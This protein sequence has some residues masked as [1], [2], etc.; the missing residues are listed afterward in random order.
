MALKTDPIAPSDLQDMEHLPADPHLL[1]AAIVDSSDDAIV[2]KNLDGIILSWNRAAERLFGYSADEVI[3]KSIRTVIP[4]ERQHEEDMIIGKLR[5]GERIDHYETVRMRKN[6][7]RFPISVTISPIRDSSGTVVAASKIARDISDRKRLDESRFRLAAIV[8]SADDAIISKDLDGIVLTWNRG[9]EKIFGYTAEE[10]IGQSI[11]CLFPDEL[12]HEEDEL[13]RKMR[14]GE[15]IDH[16]ETVRKKKNGQSVDISV[17][18]SPIRDETGNVTAVSKIARDVSDKKRVE[19][20][21]LQSEKLAAMGRMAAAV[22][23]EINNPLE[24]L[25]NLIYLAR[26]NSAPGGKA[27][28][29]LTTAEEEMERLAHMARQTLGYYKDTVSP[30]EV[31]LH[32]LIENVL[33]VYNTR[34]MSTGI[35]LDTRFNDLKKIRVSKGEM[36]QVFSNVIANALDAMRGGGVLKICTHNVTGATHDGV[37]VTIQDNGSGIEQENLPKIF[38][39]FFTTKGNVGTGIGLWVTRELLERR[40]GQISV[41]SSTIPRSSGTMV[42]IFLPFEM[43]RALPEAE[44]QKVA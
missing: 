23:H 30:V 8:N 13:L 5:A 21:L 44:R 1:L 10:M 18:I 38:E 16:Y 20:L 32:E 17:T 39:P 11:L 14:A 29:M 31:H 25:I 34:L 28:Q 7:E 4:P 12:K 9:A 6:G 42:T 27:Y 43:P 19:R 3:G 41:T 26:Q 33:T 2:S 36:L 24:S 40:G 22:A 37:E 35:A 15:R